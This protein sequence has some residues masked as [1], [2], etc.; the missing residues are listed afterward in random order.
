MEKLIR[1]W[2]GE[3]IVSR[4]DKPTGTWMFIAIH[5]SILGVPTGGTRLKSYPNPNEALLDA[6]RLAKGMTYKFAVIDFPRGGAK[7]V[8]AI[9]KDF[10]HAEREGLMSRYGK[11]LA[12]LGGIFETGA[13]L[14]TSSSDM[15]LISRQFSGVFGK[16]PKAGGA[17]DPGPETALGVFYGIQASC[18]H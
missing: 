15:D 6:M 13:D 11:W 5:S 17:G 2:D 8:L 4:F 14:G 7:A 18:E 12:D 9:P 1:D 3:Y 16:S 10:N